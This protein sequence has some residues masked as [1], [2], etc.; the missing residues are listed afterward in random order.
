MTS[1]EDDH[2]LY[3]SRKD[4]EM[5]C[6]GLDS[7]AIIREVFR[8]HGSGQTH[9][10]DEAYLGWTNARG[11]SVRNLNMPG[12]IGGSWRVAGT[13]IIN[14]NIHNPTRGQPRASGVTLL[15]DDTSARV[16]C[17]MEGAHISSL[18]TASVT[19]LAADL[20]HGPE[21][22][23]AAIIGAGALARAHIE[24]LAR[25]LPHL[26]RI[27]LFELAAERVTALQHDV[28][29][30]L[31]A[32]NIEL[33][34]TAT[35]EE[36]IRPAQLIVPVTTTT[37]GYIRFDWLQR[38]SLLVNI[39]LDDPLPEVVFKADQ[40]IVDDWNLVKS[41]SRRL[42]G[43]M[44]RQEQIIGPDDPLPATATTCRRVDAQLGDIVAGTKPGR[45]STGDR[46]LVNPFGL[47][48]EDVALAAHVYQAARDLG[49][50]T[51]L[52]R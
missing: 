34:V 38:G 8:L 50:G 33:Q 30:L 32:R 40:V 44:Y 29:P 39:S 48:I 25:R 51:P 35:A 46:I 14:G 21:I 15:Y 18:R 16:L 4:V 10:P 9:L 11:E 26:R 28:T 7:V 22:Q 41:D 12:H 27:L 1:Y 45:L 43:R 31:L 2:I 20:L 42:L 17:I 24:L 13:K 6:K 23:S 3:L 36:A 19:A 52:E 5:A 49:L 47:A 37:E